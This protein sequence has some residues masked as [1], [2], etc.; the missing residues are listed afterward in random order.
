[1]NIKNKMLLSTGLVAVVM[2]IGVTVV[3]QMALSNAAPTALLV[4]FALVF[5]TICA[6][7][8]WIGLSLSRRVNLVNRQLKEVV[9]GESDLSYRIDLQGRDEIVSLARAFNAFV[10]KIDEAL[11][12]TSEGVAALG[13][14]G[15]QLS[16][17]ANTTKEGMKKLQLNTH[18]VVVAIEEMSATAREVAANAATVDESAQSAATQ[19][20]EGAKVVKASTRATQEL[21]EEVAGAAEKIRELR[22]ETDSIG[23]I[24]DVIRGIADQTNL[25]ALNAAIEAARAGEQGRGFAVVADEVRSLARRSQES[26][27]EIQDLIERLQVRAGQA[28]EMVEKGREQAD[29]SVEEAGHATASLTRITEAVDRIT[30]M[31]AQIATAAEEQSTV[32]V[33]I[34]RN[35]VAINDLADEVVHHSDETSKVSAQVGDVLSQVSKEMCKFRFSNGQELVLAQARTAH[36][37]WKSRLRAFLDGDAQLTQEQAV[38]HHHCDLGKWYYDRGQQEFGQWSEFRAIEPPHAEIHRLIKEVIQLRASGQAER[39]EE[40]Y[41]RVVALSEEILGKLDKLADR[42]RRDRAA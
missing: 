26:T 39:A 23:S 13:S 20:L 19:A 28:V 30:S 24:L 18:A 22:Q 14:T 32:V 11:R 33:D 40:V 37:A 12:H 41:Q 15:N 17:A 8:A 7:N 35:T 42:C 2:S 4:T 1:M 9:A 29:R 31:T 36:L 6:T 5:L 16:E 25:L 3:Y 38:S 10:D 34:S 21:A 27:E